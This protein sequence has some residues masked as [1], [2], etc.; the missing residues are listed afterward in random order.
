MASYKVPG[1]YVSEI[2]GQRSPIQGVST[3]IAAFVGVTEKGP[4]N[5][6]T[7]ITSMVYFYDIFGGYSWNTYLAYSVYAF[8]A[9][10]GSSCYV[11]RAS[12]NDQSVAT[13]AGS[14]LIPGNKIIASNL[15]SW[16]QKISFEI[17]N[18]RFDPNDPADLVTPK[19]NFYVLV[20]KQ[21]ID[22]I[23]IELENSANS[24]S[25][26]D[27][28]LSAFVSKNKLGMTRDGSSY[29]L[30]FYNDFNSKDLLTGDGPD[31]SSV[32]STKI[33]K[34]SL[35]LRVETSSGND[36]ETRPKNGIAPLIGGGIVNYEFEVA[37]NTL[38][39]FKCISLLAMP[40]LVSMEA[41]SGGPEYNVIQNT[42]NKALTFCESQ[43]SI[44]YV[45]DPPL[46]QNEE[47]ILEFKN[48]GG[49]YASAINS[50][51]GALYY[52]WLWFIDPFHNKNILIPP[53]G[54]TL[55]RYAISPVYKAPAGVQDGN[56]T[57]ASDLE[58]KVSDEEQSLL[59][60]SG[61][62]AIRSFPNSGIVIWGARTVSEDDEWKYVSVRRLNTYI[63]QSLKQSLQW[64]TFEPN[65]PQLW[66]SVRSLVDTF[67]TILFRDGAFQG[68][69]PSDAFFVKCD[70]ETTTAQDIDEGILN[71]VVGFA[72]LRPA[73][74]IIISLSFEMTE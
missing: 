47:S 29:I 65:N 38:A 11:V 72:P 71:L 48:G 32:F 49:N 73:E 12:L 35:F 6:P 27:R 34:S 62:N 8:F 16:G 40:D 70:P 45:I 43:E 15:G 54:A 20:S 68:A 57:V 52:P 4:E 19:F 60:P 10:G 31:T 36:G 44:F 59:N 69:K 17:C 13:P 67:M 21:I 1:V 53:S 26:A 24:V 66:S 7:L 18:N 22:T 2:P 37:Y 51:Y 50:S 41:N 39:T 25:T 9:E 30:E 5:T 3:E 42:V 14:E 33:N 55:G 23:N 46:G 28:S 63:E 74:F 56:L 61:V 64:V 58:K